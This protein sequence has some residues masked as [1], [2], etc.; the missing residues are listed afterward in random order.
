MVGQL[1]PTGL[2]PT[3]L[4]KFARHGIELP[5]DMFGTPLD[6]AYGAGPNG[7]GWFNGGNGQ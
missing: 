7:N 1:L 4:A 6:A 5:H 2:R 3:F